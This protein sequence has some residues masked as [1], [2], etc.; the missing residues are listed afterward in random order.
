MAGKPTDCEKGS[1]SNI[2]NCLDKETIH[3]LDALPIDGVPSKPITTDDDKQTGSHKLTMQPE[4][5]DHICG[6]RIQLIT[7]QGHEIRMMDE[8]S[9]ASN[10]SLTTSDGSQQLR[11]DEMNKITV[12]TS[13]KHHFI[14]SDSTHV[15]SGVGN[16]SAEIKYVDPNSR[17]YDTVDIKSSNDF[18]STDYHYD[19]FDTPSYYMPYSE[20][21]SK[22]ELSSYMLLQTEKKHKLWLADTESH[23]RI[24]AS[25]IDGHEL[26]LLDK[27][28][29]SPNGKIQLTTK[30][31]NMQIIMD[32]DSKDMYIVNNE[33]SIYFY[34]KDE[35]EFHQNRTGPIAES[36]K[37]NL[38]VAKS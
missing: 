23:P 8:I 13:A 16:T 35:I 27:S 17:N 33:G 30:N 25:T 7:M 26:L 10:I 36:V 21:A 12:L 24:H 6:Q 34:A 38:L 29:E 15:S 5:N 31:K 32:L 28:P 37:N 18:D 11:L 22:Y 14:L 2:K 20:S 4:C 3:L 19:N 1:Q 9:E